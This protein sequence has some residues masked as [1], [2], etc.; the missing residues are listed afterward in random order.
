MAHS[1]REYSE[2]VEQVIEAFMPRVPERLVKGFN[3]MMLGGEYSMAVDDL[4]AT[5]VKRQI[6]VTPVER[7]TLRN[8]LDYQGSSAEN[9]ERLNVHEPG[10]IE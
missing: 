5:L 3:S 8:L 10:T 7:D 2:Q 9:V 4:M 6:A 1:D